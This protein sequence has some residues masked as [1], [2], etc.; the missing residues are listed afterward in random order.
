[1]MC[2]LENM[3]IPEEAQTEKIKEWYLHDGGI[4]RRIVLLEKIADILNRI[5]SKG[6]AFGDLSPSNI[7]I[8]KDPSFDALQLIDC[9]NL[10][11]VGSVEGK[12]CYT[13]KYG[14]PE[15]VNE[16][17][18]Y[19]TLTDAWSF[20]V[21]AYQLL[22]LNHPLLG[23]MVNEGEAEL[24]EKAF[25]GELPWVDD[26]EDHSNKTTN[27]LT[28]NLVL[29]KTLNALFQKTFGEKKSSWTRPGMAEWHEI[30]KSALHKFF[31]CDGCNKYYWASKEKQCP[32]CQEKK[33]KGFV[34]LKFARWE[35]LAEEGERIQRPKELNLPSVVLNIGESICIDSSL[36]FSDKTKIKIEY[37]DEDSLGLT[38]LQGENGTVIIRKK[39]DKDIDDKKERI[40]IPLKTIPIKRINET[41]EYAIHLAN[42]QTAHRIITFKWSGSK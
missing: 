17:S 41:R 2:P 15:M 24:E 19:N 30:L 1:D 23:D 37:N 18:G 8:S 9:D 11:T 14:A 10:T 31:K 25:C 35:P 32:F 40:F 3:M 16:V 28:P 21:I 6:F 39:I 38:L 34:L 36:H 22:T 33:S 13:P 5:H 26:S 29:D 12:V 20:A 27:G 42:L 7:F 4:K